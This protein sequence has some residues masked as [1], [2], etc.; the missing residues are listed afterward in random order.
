M[1]S[2]TASVLF[3]N[4][5]SCMSL[6]QPW[7]STVSFICASSCEEDKLESISIEEIVRSR[8]FL[9]D[10]DKVGG[11][12]DEEHL[13]TLR[14]VGVITCIVVLEEFPGSDNRRAVGMFDDCNWED[15]ENRV[16]RVGGASTSADELK[17]DGL[18]NRLVLSLRLG[19]IASNRNGFR[20]L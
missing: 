16:G 10:F 14:F 9:N 6:L 13:R 20:I 8:A 12:C 2:N 11:V 5:S 17:D 19:V 15:K 1:A 18:L 4:S 7:T 3:S